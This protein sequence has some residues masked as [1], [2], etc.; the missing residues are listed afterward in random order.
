MSMLPTL[1]SREP[2]AISL[3]VFVVSVQR[4]IQCSIFK[5][6]ETA[7]Q[8]MQS[9]AGTATM[10]GQSLAFNIRCA[11][12]LVLAVPCMNILRPDCDVS[13]AFDML[14]QESSECVQDIREGQGESPTEG[15]T[16]SIDWDGY[17]IGYY[18]GS[19]THSI[20]I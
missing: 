16:C 11:S 19:P 1:D 2:V 15:S 17:T 6:A 18:V 3:P 20:P 5:K 14:C 9:P 7:S 13:T 8:A 10:F 12:L 4:R